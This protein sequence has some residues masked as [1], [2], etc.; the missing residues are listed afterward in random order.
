MLGTQTAGGRNL[1]YSQLVSLLEK[2]FGPGQLAENHLVELRHRRQG[3]RE[4]LQELCQSVREMS[5]LAYPEL[6]DEGRDRLARGHFSDAVEDQAIR[7]GIFRARPITLDEAVSAAIATEGFIRVEEQRSGR[8][9]KFARSLDNPEYPSL[10][11]LEAKVHEN[12]RH[13]EDAISEVKK[14]VEVIA[15][16]NQRK[17][18]ANERNGYRRQREPAPGEYWKCVDRNTGRE[19]H[20]SCVGYF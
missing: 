13:M 11:N 19:D 8:K 16:Q 1:T 9:V 20:P 4:T 3:A 7:E 5:G 17:T 12:N 6:T 18:E 10:L 15:R 14:M 2:R